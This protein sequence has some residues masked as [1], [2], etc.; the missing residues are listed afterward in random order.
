MI[1]V[2]HNRLIRGKLSGG[3]TIW[4][5]TSYN[6]IAELELDSVYEVHFQTN[7]KIIATVHSNTSRNGQIYLITAY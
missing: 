5:L 7:E 6:K 2:A 3:V 4:S 1:A